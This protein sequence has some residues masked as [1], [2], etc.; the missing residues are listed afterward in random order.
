M[1]ILRT[2]NRTLSMQRAFS[3]RSPHTRTRFSPMC[4]VAAV[5]RCIRGF[6]SGGGDGGRAD[7]S[8]RSLICIFLHVYVA[9]RDR[10]FR[11]YYAIHAA[12][13]TISFAPELQLARPSHGDTMELFL[14]RTVGISAAPRAEFECIGDRLSFGVLRRFELYFLIFLCSLRLRL[15]RIPRSVLFLHDISATVPAHADA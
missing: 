2:V 12:Y 4:A 6:G 8:S 15:D 5:D 10:S 1:H 7:I 14:L 9:R 13:S 3:A 11:R